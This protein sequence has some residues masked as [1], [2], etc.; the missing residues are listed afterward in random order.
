MSDTKKKVIELLRVSTKKQAEDDRAGLPAQRATNK[1]TAEKYDLE[2]VETVKLID[3]SGAEV[4]W[5]EDFQ[6]MLKTIERPDISGVV[7]CEF[8]RLT[9]PENKRDGAILQTFADTNTVF[10][11]PTGVMDFNDD[12]GSLQGDVHSAISAYERRKL[13]KRTWRGKEERRK[14]GKWTAGQHSL[15]YGVG[16]EENKK[17]AEFRYWYKPEAAKVKQVFKR[18]LAG[19]QNYSEH[20]E[21]LGVART[22]AKLMLKNPIYMGWYVLD[23]MRDQSPAGVRRDKKTG[24]PSRDKRSI[25]RPPEKTIPPRK[26]IEKGLVSEAEFRKVQSLIAAKQTNN[27]KKRT[28]I[29]AFAYAHKLFCGTC[30]AL[31]R[32][33]PQAKRGHFYYFCSNKK[34]KDKKTGKPLCGTSYLL[35]ERV[36]FVLDF[37]VASHLRNSHWLERVFKAEQKRLESGYSEKDCERAQALLDSLVQKRQ[38]VVDLAVEGVIGKEERD[39]RLQK[40][41]RETQE[42]RKVLDEHTK[43]VP[44][45]SPEEIAELAKP[46]NRW[47]DLDREDKQ[48]LL[49]S[50][51]FTFV[52]DGSDPKKPTVKGM[53]VGYETPPFTAQNGQYT[54][55]H[56]A[57]AAAISQET[58]N[59]LQI[60]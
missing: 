60:D 43:R 41:D 35:R 56:R 26:V 44:I 25:T 33:Q 46:L 13:K 34:R 49:K 30:G 51:P 6:R 2:I 27:L 48:R 53:Y 47:H 8:E 14:Q 31:L 12:E 57:T 29:G 24:K 9:R 28:Q 19:N 10:Y 38:R 45:W 7:A 37:Q 36:E 4:L 17:T 16:Y 42:A 11:L 20:A 18:F 3:V 55:D 52:V 40:I 22:T 23:K 59:R 32:T 21:Y 58:A 54:I 15:P 5:N 1:T 39:S 50:L